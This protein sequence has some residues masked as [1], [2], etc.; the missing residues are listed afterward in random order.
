M[1][2]VHRVEYQ[3]LTLS[4]SKKHLVVAHP[5]LTEL[6]YCAQ[7]FGRLPKINSKL[8]IPDEKHANSDKKKTKNKNHISNKQI[9]RRQKCVGIK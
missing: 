7:H 5:K 6:S 4:I 8:L 3:N 2:A 1:T 9:K